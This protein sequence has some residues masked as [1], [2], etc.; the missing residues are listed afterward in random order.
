MPAMLSVTESDVNKGKAMV[1]CSTD[2]AD[3]CC[4]VSKMVSIVMCSAHV[5][6][7]CVILTHTCT[8]EL[9]QFNAFLCM[10]LSV[11]IKNE[12]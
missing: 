8:F 7:N 9:S 5:H 4:K 2:K 10:C 3:I 12:Y 6:L 1:D 11:T